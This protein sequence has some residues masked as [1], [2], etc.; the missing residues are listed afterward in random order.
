M[1]E[2]NKATLKTAFQGKNDE[3]ALYQLYKVYA[4]MRQRAHLFD[5]VYNYYY[6]GMMDA[7][8]E[9]AELLGVNVK[10]MNERFEN[11]NTFIH[12]GMWKLEYEK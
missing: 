12:P 8:L 2:M 1:E 9:M 6:T 4:Q 7:F 3:E 11:E 5:I 10:K